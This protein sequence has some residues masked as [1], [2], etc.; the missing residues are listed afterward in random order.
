[1]EHESDGDTNYNWCSRNDLGKERKGLEVG[2]WTETI[3]TT[4]L[5]RSARILRK[6]LET[7]GDS[8]SSERLS[9]N[10]DVKNSQ[11]LR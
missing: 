4:V 2:G 3:K 11:G 6:V 1:M 9:A 5:L 8:R 7:C 10:A